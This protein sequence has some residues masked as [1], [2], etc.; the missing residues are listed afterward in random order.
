MCAVICTAALLGTVFSSPA[1][2]QTRIM[3]LGDSI[4]DGDCSTHLGGYR[5]YLY[6]LLG[7]AGVSF[8]FVG[9]LQGGNGL[10]DSDHEGHSGF[11]A[12]QLDVN[13]YL[14]LNPPDIVLLEIGTNDV[15]VGESA[16][17]VRDDISAILDAIHAH[18]PAIK[19]ILS[20][21]IPRKDKTSL[22]T[23][24]ANLNALLP[25]LVAAK[26]AGGQDVVLV[27]VAA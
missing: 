26:V 18:N 16:T 13:G 25:D 20:T 11:R 12:D 5:I 9:S 7:N 15:S 14:A 21:V 2:G 22:Q 6:N 8:D 23:V 24:T 17:E 3:P 27:D 1:A 4:T 10:P 19:V